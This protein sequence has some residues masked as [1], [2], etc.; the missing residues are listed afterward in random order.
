[1]HRLLILFLSF[2]FI[3]CSSVNKK[4]VNVNNPYKDANKISEKT[5]QDK[6]WHLKDIINDTLPGISLERA[7]NTILKNIKGT[8][9][10][11]AVLDTKID[12]NHDDFKNQ[13][14]LNPNEIANNNIDDNNNGYIDDVHGWN[15]LGN[16]K[17]ESVMIE[18][19]EFIRIIRQFEKHFQRLTNDTISKD[20]LNYIRAKH[21]YEK[22]MVSTK[23]FLKRSN[24]IMSFYYEARA[25]LK[26][27]FPDYNYSYEVL[28]KIDTTGNGLSKYV[29]EIRL[30]LKY[31]DTDQNM[32]KGHLNTKNT[33][34]KKLNL[35][36]FPRKIVGDDPDDINDSIYGNN[37]ISDHL[38]IIDHGT[39]VTGMITQSTNLCKDKEYIK[40]MPV[41][42]LPQGG[43]THDKD[44]A[45]GIRYA[46][47]N[48]AKVINM[49]FSS[50]FSSHTEWLKEAFLYA[51]KHNVLIVSAAGNSN[52]NIDD[53]LHIYP[54]DSYNKEPEFCDNF[55]LV[56]ASSKN[57]DS[58]LVTF[59]DY[60]KIK[61]D[62]FA[63]GADVYSTYPNNK[64]KLDNGSF[65]SSGLTSK[66]AALLFSYYPNLTA[67]QVKH[68]I[69]DSGVTYT[70]PVKTP[71]EE[72]KNKTTP[73][74]E[75]SKSGKIV[76]AYN[77][78][79]MADSISTANN[80]Y[81]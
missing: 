48:G 8:E 19:Y 12:I 24:E 44:I 53:K 67:S 71:T 63:P 43:S 65:L 1:M 49:S 33:Y 58:T 28:N 11:V 30:V 4:H 40:I 38:G 68:I 34:T 6:S 26:E 5:K 21:E 69:M 75:L 25:A 9:V 3:S 60:G 42:V 59:S 31:N 2:I 57:L 35:E 17:G 50:D 22:E 76:N 7:Y 39:R 13:V 16:S 66:V 20:Y 15:F 77:A 55:L 46:V 51:E 81:K 54:H 78:F 14:W 73:F 62:V 64:Y 37:I 61:A 80:N 41:I 45:L 23:K 18:N 29:E 74:N 10:I 56:G 52:Q 79:I 47:N 72:D 70:F 36:Y 32:E 27:F